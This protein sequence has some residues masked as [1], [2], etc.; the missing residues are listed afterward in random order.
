M[1]NQIKLERVSILNSQAFNLGGGYNE[2]GQQCAAADIGHGLVYF[3]DIARD[4]DFFFECEFK[5]SAI[6]QAYLYNQSVH[7]PFEDYT[8]KSDARQVLEALAETAP[9]L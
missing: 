7:V 1:K 4:L 2:K 9:T 5:V 8:S 6:K 3:V